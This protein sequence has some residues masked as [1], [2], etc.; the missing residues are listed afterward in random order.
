MEGDAMI[1]GTYQAQVDTPIGAKQ[2]TLTL[3]QQG[4]IFT[5]NLHVLGGDTVIEN[6]VLEGVALSF[7]GTLSVPFIGALPFTFEGTYQND[8]IHG[9]A[10]TKMGEIAIAGKRA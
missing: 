10:R 6:G 5:G 7:S 2:G 8:Q 3:Q 4:N 1:T 9:T